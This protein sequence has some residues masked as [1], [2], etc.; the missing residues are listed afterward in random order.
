MPD[1]TLLAHEL[2]GTEILLC[3]NELE[4][5]IQRAPYLWTK[6]MYEWLVRH[7]ELGNSKVAKDIR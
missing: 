5:I 7:W 1:P 2:L 4:S 6:Y 3:A